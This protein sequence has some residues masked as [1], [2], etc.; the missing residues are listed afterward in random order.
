[1]IAPSRRVITALILSCGL[2]AMLTIAQL[3]GAAAGIREGVQSEGAVPCV[4]GHRFEPGPI[5]GGHNRQ[6]TPAEFE[7]RTRELMA[8]SH[9]SAGSCSVLPDRRRFTRFPALRR[10]R[11]GLFRYSEL[12]TG[13]AGRRRTQPSLQ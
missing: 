3:S 13:Y 1:M 6:P 11:S 2:S 5:V 8:W 9:R 7:A 4:I 10:R 12:A